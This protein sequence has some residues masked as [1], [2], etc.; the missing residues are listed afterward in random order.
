M[1]NKTQLHNT[2]TIPVPSSKSVHLVHFFD[3]VK[4]YKCNK[5]ENCQ[6]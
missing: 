4:H 1:E 5:K 6:G 2:L 3:R